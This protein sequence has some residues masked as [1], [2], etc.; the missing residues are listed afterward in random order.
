VQ[1][2]YSC[3][4]IENILEIPIKNEYEKSLV[5]TYLEFEGLAAL[6]QVGSAAYMYTV[7]HLVPV[8]Y[9]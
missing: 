2:E 5:N 4:A 6:T 7:L 9:R 1:Y 8:P 3:P